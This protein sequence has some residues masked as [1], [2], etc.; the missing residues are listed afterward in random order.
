MYTSLRACYCVSNWN[1]KYISDPAPPHPFSPGIKVTE[2]PRY[3][4]TTRVDT[5]KS[6]AGK[7]FAVK[8]RSVVSFREGR[9]CK[10]GKKVVN[11]I[12]NREKSIVGQKKVGHKINF[13]GVSFS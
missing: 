5:R 6:Q 7:W 3:Q 10:S 8:S 4:L 9:L 13:C 12:S 11:D 2:A 1:G